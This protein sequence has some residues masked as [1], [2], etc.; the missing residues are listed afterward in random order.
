MSD[1]DSNVPRRLRRFY[2]HGERVPEDMARD[3]RSN[4]KDN[5]VKEGE[6]HEENE[7]WMN[8]PPASHSRRNERKENAHSTSPSTES[9]PG[10][11][12]R[13]LHGASKPA[14]T[15]MDHAL[16]LHEKGKFEEKTPNMSNQAMRQTP[17]ASARTQSDIQKALQELRTL[18]KNDTSEK[19]KSTVS[20]TSF[21]FTPTGEAPHAPSNDEKSSQLLHSDELSPRE[22]AEQRKQ[23][24]NTSTPSSS[25]PSSSRPSPPSSSN[26]P[27]H[28]RRRLGQ[29]VDGERMDREETP[30]TPTD[31]QDEKDDDDFKS[32]FSDDKNKDKKKK[33]VKDDMDD[34]EEELEL[35]E[36]DK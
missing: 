20:L 19:N 35:F 13:V 22:R 12:G 3:A 17:P 16:G 6:N 36:D 8:A 33:K 7:P 34:D 27:A 28:I 25:A 24:T 30:A 21:H 26:T 31:S 11:F 29:V 23:R 14:V 9:K 10:L 2:R 1:N 32:L 5:P 4:T 15:P 18:A